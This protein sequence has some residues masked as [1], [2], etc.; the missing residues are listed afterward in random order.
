MNLLLIF[1]KASY[2]LVQN[3][4]CV[5]DSMVNIYMCVCEPSLLAL[6]GIF[7]FFSLLFNSLT[8]QAEFMEHDEKALP[9]DIRL[10]GALAEKVLF[11]IF[12]YLSYMKKMPFPVIFSV[13]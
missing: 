8:F 5:N 2:L 7:Y 4:H 12:F 9:I 11:S 6:L 10:L 13:H 3:M 1:V